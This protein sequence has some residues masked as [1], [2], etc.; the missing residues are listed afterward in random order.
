MRDTFIV[1]NWLWWDTYSK[2][3]LIWFVLPKSTRNFKLYHKSTNRALYWGKHS[4]VGTGLRDLSISELKT[5]HVSCN[6]FSNHGYDWQSNSSKAKING[7]SSMLF[8]LITKSSVLGKHTLINKKLKRPS[9]CKYT[10]LER[11]VSWE[12]LSNTGFKYLFSSRGLAKD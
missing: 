8:N 4:T 7:Y 2:F 11:L 10:R 9:F 3:G 6:D 12:K 5:T 1:R